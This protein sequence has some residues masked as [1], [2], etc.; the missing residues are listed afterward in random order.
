MKLVEN[1]RSIMKSAHSQW[2]Q[3]LAILSL[4]V[5]EVLFIVGG[6]DTNP[7]VWWWVALGLCIYGIIGRV[8]D[9]GISQ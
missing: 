6:I 8:K 9:Q 5:P 3:Y 4:T 2:A 7:S 1:W